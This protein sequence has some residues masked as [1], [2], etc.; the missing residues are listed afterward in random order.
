MAT[1]PAQL[2]LS[3]AVARWKKFPTD[4]IKAELNEAHEWIKES[5][6]M[7]TFLPNRVHQ[8][9]FGWQNVQAVELKDAAIATVQDYANFV[10]AHIKPLVLSTGATSA[11]TSGTSGSLMAT[12]AEVPSSPV[13]DKDETL[14]LFASGAGLD[15]AAIARLKEN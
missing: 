1:D 3:L 14:R 12:A 8:A 2:A 15:D 11:T 6:L 5:Q 10:E 4:P 7:N 9:G 13:P